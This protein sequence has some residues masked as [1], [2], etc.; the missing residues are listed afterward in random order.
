MLAGGKQGQKRRPSDMHMQVP[1][2]EAAQ[3]YVCAGDV[4]IGGQVPGAHE[5][6]NNSSSLWRL[7]HHRMT[8]RNLSWAK[9]TLSDQAARDA[10]AFG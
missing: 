1:G 4:E 6:P 7:I 2:Y 10:E 8:A 9:L 3:Y 5:H